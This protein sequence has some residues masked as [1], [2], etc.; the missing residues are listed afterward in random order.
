MMRLEI[1]WLFFKFILLYRIQHISLGLFIRLRFT[2]LNFIYFHFIWGS[3]SFI[4]E[5][6]PF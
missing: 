3:L 5:N 2:D 1:S 6:S 4:N